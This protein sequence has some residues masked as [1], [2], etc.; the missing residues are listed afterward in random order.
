MHPVSAAHL[1]ITVTCSGKQTSFLAAKI[2]AR[3]PSPVKV[4]SYAAVRFSWGMGAG[5]RGPEVSLRSQTDK[6]SAHFR[7]H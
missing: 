7:G 3:T 6:V 1:Y 4:S 2:A 5:Q